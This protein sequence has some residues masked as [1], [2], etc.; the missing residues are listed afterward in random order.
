MVTVA[1]ASTSSL[2]KFSAAMA[3]S[4]VLFRA[5]Q[6][7]TIIRIGLSTVVNY[8]ELLIFYYKF[9]R[10]Q[11]HYFVIACASDYENHGMVWI[12]FQFIELLNYDIVL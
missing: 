9:S 3:N 12:L 1:V 2:H 5:I 10:L 4:S 8:Y 6:F 11:V 7:T